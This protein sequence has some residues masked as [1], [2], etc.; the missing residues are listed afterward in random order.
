MAQVR[1]PQRRAVRK[2]RYLADVVRRLKA[3]YAFDN[4]GN[5]SNP[6]DELVYIVLSTRTRGTVFGRTFRALKKK[7]PQWEKAARASTSSIEKVLAPAGLSKKKARWLKE[8][9]REIINRE[10]SASLG[11]LKTLRSSDAEVYLTSLPGVGLKTARC[12]LMYSLG[13]RVFPVDANARRLLER[14]GLLDHSVH[15]NYVHNAA[16]ELVPPS[17]RI[18]LHIYAV[19]HGR[20]T[21]LP[22]NPRC[23]T[24][25]LLELCA[26]GRTR[27][28]KTRS[29]TLRNASQVR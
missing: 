3:S 20:R 6:L 9:L 14:L 26:H 28:P 12:V 8:T 21:C 15:Y 10:G 2:D 24:C 19:I 23:T 22:R 7:F 29:A 18:D 11:K 5:F 16:Q 4:L 27:V 25:P 13:R 1:T 17:L